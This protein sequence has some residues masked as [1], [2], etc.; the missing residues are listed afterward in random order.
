MTDWNELTNRSL[1][2][3]KTCDPL[4]R[5]T[6]FWGP[7]L[8]Q[9]LGELD[10]RG[11]DKFK[12]WPTAFYWFYPRYGTGFSYAT[13]DHTIAAARQ[14]VPNLN[15]TWVKSA[16]VASHEA[17]RDF[18]VARLFWDTKRW[19]IDLEGFG[20]SMAGTPSQYFKFTGQEHGWTRPYLNYFICM[21]AL[22]HHVDGPPKR[23]LEI[24]GGYGVL[25]EFLMQRD[26]E[27]V[28]VDVDIPPLLTVASWYL[29]TL[30]GDRV[31]IYGKDTPEGRIPVT[32]SGVYPNYR[33]PDLDGEFDVFVNSFSF[34]EM[35]PDVVKS[36]IDIVASKNVEYVVSLNSRAGKPKKSDGHEIGVVDPVTSARIVEWFGEH[37]YELQ[38]AYDSPV[39]A[40]A[41]Q[42]VVLRKRR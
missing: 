32:G 37:G 8:D 2:E 41:G 28:Y 40:G 31:A 13:I 1:E 9:L 18:D 24:G 15:A 6:S 29:R 21:A 33:L 39:V 36:Y 3:L 34:Q 7:G 26:P 35:E 42:L 38:G 27:V 25:G 19:P 17:R 11:L 5:P 14:V 30:F 23:F 22:S 20:E 4:F 16:L 10:Q 12:S